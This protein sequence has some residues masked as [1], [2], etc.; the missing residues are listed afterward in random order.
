MVDDTN[1]PERPRAEP[2]ILPPER[3]GGRV[4]ESQWRINQGSYG[5]DADGAWRGQRI[6]VMRPGPLGLIAIMLV[7]GLIVGA[8]VLAVIGTLLVWIP[9]VAIC[10]AI[11]AV[12]RF[13]RR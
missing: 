7:L 11:A 3:T 10:V 13:L 9:A 4:W 1:P 8:I 6:F 5:N 2:E 12:Y